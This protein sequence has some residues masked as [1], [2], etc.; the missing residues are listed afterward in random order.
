MSYHNDKKLVCILVWYH[1]NNYS[2]YIYKGKNYKAHSA[3]ML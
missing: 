2:I 1:N 3:S